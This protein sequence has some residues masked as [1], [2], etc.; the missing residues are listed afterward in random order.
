MSLLRVHEGICAVPSLNKW[1]TSCFVTNRVPVL[2]VKKLILV[3]KATLSHF[4]NNSSPPLSQHGRTVITWNCLHDW[5]TL[6]SGGLLI[7]APRPRGATRGHRQRS[8]QSR[9]FDGRAI[10]DSVVLPAEPPAAAMTPQN[11]S[12]CSACQTKD[13]HRV[14]LLGF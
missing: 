9:R 8:S 14:K 11:T 10:D 2:K 4:L 12:D 5:K 3:N 1:K 6:F 13:A 7:S